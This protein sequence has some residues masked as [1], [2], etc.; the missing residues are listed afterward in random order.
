MLHLKS[1]LVKWLKAGHTIRSTQ[2]IS[3]SK[4]IKN[5]DFKICTVNREIDV[6]KNLIASK[7]K[8]LKSLQN[9]LFVNK[10]DVDN[11]IQ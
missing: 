7:N 1:I 10:Y 6:I 4:L 5:F 3:F 8:S 11:F 9:N 2:S